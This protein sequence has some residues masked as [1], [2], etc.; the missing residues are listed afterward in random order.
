MPENPLSLATRFRQLSPAR[1]RLIITGAVLGVFVFLFLISP[2]PKP[3]V[4]STFPPSTGGPTNTTSLPHKD[5][6]SGRRIDNAYS[7]QSI[8]ALPS[9]SETLRNTSN[10]FVGVPGDPHI[11]YSAE[12][13][14]GTKE[15]AH[16][17]TSLEEILDRHHGYIAKLRM[18]GQPSGSVLNATLRIP[19]S[20]YRAAL[21]DLKS[22]GNV[23]HEEESA[24]EVTQQ[25]NN[26]EARLLNAQSEE[27]KL[28]QFL[29][30]RSPKFTD[31][32]PVERQLALLRTEMQRIQAERSTYANP[33]AFANISFSLQE[34]RTAPAETLAAQLK[35]AAVSGFGDVIGTLS[36]ILLFVI[37]RGPMLFLW[38]IL[39][40]FP[41]RFFWRRHALWTLREAESTKA[42]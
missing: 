3:P 36:T 16:S 22:V 13:T 40:Y 26:F 19:S 24:D 29:D 27:R 34:E 28:Q 25:Y 18:V 10:D 33:V 42:T 6:G 12:L 2:S 30:N 23:E 9:A 8:A 7:R 32:T 38:A 41:A 35:A 31:Y 17:R 11:A 20:E 4:T 21:T 5:D 14:L 39:L 1:R 15:F 37:S